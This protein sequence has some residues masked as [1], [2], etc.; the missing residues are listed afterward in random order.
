MF[1]DAGVPYLYT[2]RWGYVQF[3]GVGVREYGVLCYGYHSDGG[4]EMCGAVLNAV[5]WDEA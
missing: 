2:V 1:N 5:C 3:Y 4:D